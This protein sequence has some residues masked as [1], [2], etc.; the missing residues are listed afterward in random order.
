MAKRTIQ[1]M[2]KQFMKLFRI[3]S[4]L[5]F[6]R[7]FFIHIYKYNYVYIGCINSEK[8]PSECLE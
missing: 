8:N 2:E 4:K 1:A 3:F 5:E 6:R 7:V